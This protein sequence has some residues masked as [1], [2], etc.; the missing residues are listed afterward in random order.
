M[1]AIKCTIAQFPIAEAPTYVALS[2]AWGD[3]DDKSPVQIDGVKLFIAT[4]LYGALSAI[5]EKGNDVL[6]WADALCIDQENPVEKSDQIKL[7]TSIYAKAVSVAIWLG[8]EADSS[9]SA[10]EFLK[11]LQVRSMS[12]QQIRSLISSPESQRDLAAVATLFSR[13]Y[14]TRVWVVQEVVNASR[15][16]VYCGSKKLPW[17]V[18]KTASDIFWQ[19]KKDIDHQFSKTSARHRRYSALPNSQTHAHALVYEGPNGLLDRRILQ[20]GKEEVLLHVLR[21]CR[22]KQAGEARDKVFALLGVL[23][24]SIR[25]DIPVDYKSSVKEIFTN[26]VDYLLYTTDSL[27]VICE[28]VHFPQHFSS[29]NLPSWV[30]DWSHN[31]E[32]TSLSQSYS[33]SAAGKTIAQWKFIDTHLRNELEI[34]AIYLDTIKYHG[35]PVGTLCTLADYLM[36][37]LHWRAL[38]IHTFGRSAEGASSKAAHEAFCRTLNLSQTPLEWRQ[39]T[40]EWMQACYHV[41]ASLLKER[42]PYLAIDSEL[43]ACAAPHTGIERE[44]RRQ[45]L[46]THFGKYMMGRSFCITERKHMGMGSGFMLPEDIIV[47]PLGCRTPIILRQEGITPRRYRFIGDIYVDKYMDGRALEMYRSHEAEIEKFVLI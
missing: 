28:S 19:Y 24:E 37:F 6:V 34:S 30:P 46:Q 38:L 39:H 45:F 25:K 2:Y 10:M 13:S 3:A 42:L 7:M 36:S 9:E 20:T 5:R 8:P 18:L 41:F 21:A 31:P 17:H 16:N 14:W 33:F 29:Y 23:P 40:D 11:D 1:A 44:N 43:E 12:E 26:V 27:D 47:V 15:I 22:R 35:F 32:T 4:S